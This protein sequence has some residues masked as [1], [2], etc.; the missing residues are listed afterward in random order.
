[1]VK[2]LYS[3]KNVK[4]KKKEFENMWQYLSTV[5]GGGRE[6]GSVLLQIRFK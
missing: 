4:K 5:G 2:Q 1:M 3:N 6:G